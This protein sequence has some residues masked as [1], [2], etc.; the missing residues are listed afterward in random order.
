MSP[1]AAR[2][3]GCPFPGRARLVPGAGSSCRLC[4][5]KG[6]QEATA[7]PAQVLSGMEGHR[8]QRSPASS[9]DQAGGA[10]ALRAAVQPSRLTNNVRCVADVC[11]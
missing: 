2:A 1:R 11:C 3:P 9:L 4:P 6:A 10:S 7:L 8:K 5:G